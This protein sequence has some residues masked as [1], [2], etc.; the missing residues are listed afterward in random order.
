MNE[1]ISL[2]IIW[3]IIEFVGLFCDG[4]S[5]T[6]YQDLWTKIDAKLESF[7]GFIISLLVA[8]IQTLWLFYVS[9][10]SNYVENGEEKDVAFIIVFVP[11]I[12]SISKF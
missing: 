12:G 1:V 2:K 9:L 4:H 10:A 11:I 3:N 5:A 6:L 7:L 8:A